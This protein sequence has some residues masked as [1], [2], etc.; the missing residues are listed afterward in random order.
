MSDIL[1]STL[2]MLMESRC[3]KKNDCFKAMDLPPPLSDLSNVTKSI[4]DLHREFAVRYVAS[5]SFRP[6][7]LSAYE[8]DH[9]PT[10]TVGHGWHEYMDHQNGA[11][12]IITSRAPTDNRTIS[13]PFRHVTFEFMP[14]RL[15]LQVKYLRSY[16]NA[17]TFMVSV[18]GGDN[19]GLD[20]L[21]RTRI[22]SSIPEV[23]AMELTVVEKRRCDELKPEDRK[24]V[25]QY[26]GS[27]SRDNHA[28]HELHRRGNQKVK[29]FEISICYSLGK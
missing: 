20:A 6:A 7:N 15:I 3:T 18:C 22:H 16:K 4:C 10:G 11:G 29:I 17:G 28:N 19:R 5:S 9:F 13:I 12:L 25:L 14:E 26:T 2:T 24:V 21:T 8:S 27:V 23:Y 1:A